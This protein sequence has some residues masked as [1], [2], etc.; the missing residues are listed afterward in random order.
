[1]KDLLLTLLHLAVTTAK[2]CRPGGVRAVI[3]ENLLLK[4]QTDR[5]ASCA[6]AGAEP[7]AERPADLRIPDAL[8]QSTCADLN[9]VRWV[10]H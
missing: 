9:N 8:P 4:Q 1:M 2:L 10:S 3:T 7:D 6:P 5:P